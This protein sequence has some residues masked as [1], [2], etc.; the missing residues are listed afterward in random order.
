MDVVEFMGGAGDGSSLDGASTISRL[1]KAAQD[2]QQALVGQAR[3][4]QELCTNIGQMT[5]EDH[6]RLPHLFSLVPAHITTNLDLEQVK[7]E[8]LDLLAQPGEMACEYPSL[9]QTSL[10]P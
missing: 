3:L 8:W 5:A 4:L 10:H 9:S 2:P 1:P 7:A 6:W